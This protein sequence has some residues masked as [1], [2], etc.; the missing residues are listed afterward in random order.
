M[1]AKWRR[2]RWALVIGIAGIGTIALY[3]W[4]VGFPMTVARADRL[5]AQG[6]HPGQTREEVEAWLAS[7][8]VP[9]GCGFGAKDTCYCVLHRR[10]D[11]TFKGWWMDCWGRQ[12]VAE[13]AGLDVDDV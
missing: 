2:S 6:V 13:C 11:A 10:E 8:G 9:P 12:T 7:Q 3:Y 1:T 5:A 4:A